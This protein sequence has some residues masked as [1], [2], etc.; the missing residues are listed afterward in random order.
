MRPGRQEQ[1]GPPSEH[2]EVQR[3]LFFCPQKS[4][5]EEAARLSPPPPPAWTG[6]AAQ[7][8]QTA[9]RDSGAGRRESRGP[10]S[11][12]AGRL[13]APAALAK[14]AG[15]EEGRG[16][17]PLLPGPQS[18][19]RPRTGPSPG[20]PSG[21]S[22]PPV[23]ARCS[24]AQEVGATTVRRGQPGDWRDQT[25]AGDLPHPASPRAGSARGG[26]SARRPRHTRRP[27]PGNSH[28]CPAPSMR[29]SPG[30][31]WPPG[32]ARVCKTGEKQVKVKEEKQM[33][34]LHY[35]TLQK[36]NVPDFMA[37]FTTL[38]ITEALQVKLLIW[39]IK[40][41]APGTGR[42][43]CGVEALAWSRTRANWALA[44][45]TL[46][47]APQQRKRLNGTACFWSAGSL[48]T[49]TPSK[50]CPRAGQDQWTRELQRQGRSLWPPCTGSE[51]AAPTLPQLSW[52]PLWA[53]GQGEARWPTRDF[54][55]ELAEG[56]E[57]RPPCEFP[58]GATPRP[59]TGQSKP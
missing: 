17:A 7:N 9:P 31:W 16:E 10:V 26:A 24:T 21:A 15:G 51:G 50:G 4:W 54:E 59:P 47:A 58:V 32:P 39:A 33:A 57:E 6:E 12:E 5:L 38:M 1:W 28:P 18:K 42:K 49:T 55:L 45:R 19:G 25:N 3:C 35:H 27:A 22:L 29:A 56:G 37:P 2:Q 41:Y 34:P 23:Q 8:V 46:Q 13:W 48:S 30:G 36:M 44:G 40:P 53:G 43:G 52:L 14:R 20:S 11:T